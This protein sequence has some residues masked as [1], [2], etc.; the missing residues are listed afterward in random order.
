MAK[1]MTSHQKEVAELKQDKLDLK[2]KLKEHSRGYLNETRKAFATALM[3]AFAFLMALSWRE[4]I[5]QWVNK[6]GSVSPLQ[7]E[8]FS[9]V[10][11]TLICVVGIL[12][13]TKYVVVKEK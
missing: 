5:T 13:V 8:V 3:A 12:L 4:V 9:A 10:I 11:V 2:N 7:G 6:I 1:K